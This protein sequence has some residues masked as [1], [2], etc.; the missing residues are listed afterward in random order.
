MTVTVSIRRPANE[1]DRLAALRRYH[2]VDT[3][4]AAD[5]D[6]LARMA[7]VMCGT[8][9]A[10]ISLLDQERVWHK[11]AYGCR[12]TQMDRD[13]HYCS[14]TILEERG[15]RIADLRADARTAGMA[16]TVAQP[17]YRMYC[18]VNLDAGPAGIEGDDSDIAAR[19]AALCHGATVMVALSIA[20]CASTRDLVRRGTSLP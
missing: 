20:V 8:P 18:G 13:A 11:S 1:S 10:F 14:W 4:V 12:L 6:F 7:A 19:K 15:L 2:I 5:F 17:R 16:L 3:P 9:Y